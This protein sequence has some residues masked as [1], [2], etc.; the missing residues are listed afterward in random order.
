MLV[1]RSGECG[2]LRE[3]LAGAREGRAGVLVL[4]EESGIGKTRL[5]G[6]AVD[7]AD[8]FQVVHAQ[9][10]ESEMEIAFAGLSWVVDRCSPAAPAFFGSG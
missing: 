9:G 1:G 5:L 4:R 2:R 6:F 3:L 8:G 10:H 7:I